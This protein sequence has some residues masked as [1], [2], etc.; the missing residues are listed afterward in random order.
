MAT[1]NEMFPSQWLTAA[2]ID[3]ELTVTI[4]SDNPVESKEFKA[5]GKAT[6]DSKPV[7]YFKAPKGTKPLILN[8]TNW[9]TIGQVLGSDDCNTWAGKQVT[10][11]VTPVESFGE[12]TMGIR[13]KPQ[14]PRVAAPNVTKSVP[15]P[16]PEEFHQADFYEDCPPD[17]SPVNF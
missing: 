4:S 12:T 15:R 5:P 16:E 9:K 7:L 17:D 3:G 1:Y 2:D 11:Y 14:R 6:P 8:K 10:L 13:V